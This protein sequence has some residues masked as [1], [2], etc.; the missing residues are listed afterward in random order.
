MFLLFTLEHFISQEPL[1]RCSVR[2]GRRHG[3]GH[4]PT[5]KSHKRS[6]QYLNCFFY[7]AIGSNK[8]DSNSQRSQYELK[9]SSSNYTGPK[10]RSYAKCIHNSEIKMMSL[11]THICCSKPVCL[12]LLNSVEHR[13][14]KNKNLLFFVHTMEVIGLQFGL[15][16]NVLQNIFCVNI[17]CVPQKKKKSYMFRT[18]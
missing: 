18:T 13:F 12:T 2:C 15:V 3:M 9:H 4:S 10:D 8:R 16:P 1:V 14:C 17:Y 6:I 11:F 5:G 7:I